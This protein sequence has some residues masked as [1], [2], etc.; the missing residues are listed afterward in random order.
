[1]LRPRIALYLDHRNM[2]TYSKNSFLQTYMPQSC[3]RRP[4]KSE[5]YHQV[6]DAHEMTKSVDP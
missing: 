3:L 6:N 4:V 2:D 5:I 1:M